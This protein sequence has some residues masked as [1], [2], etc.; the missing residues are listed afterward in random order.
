MLC[1]V[2]LSCMNYGASAQVRS[3]DSGQDF[4]NRPIRVVV[5]Q[6]PGGASDALA[7]IIGQKLA[8]QWRSQLIIDNRGGAGG[9]IGTDIVARSVANGYT[10][11]VTY[12]GTYA[13]N[14][15]LY[16][17]LPFDSRKDFA[18]VATLAAVPFIMVVNNSLPANTLAEFIAIA[19]AKPGDLKYGAANGSVNHLLGVMLDGR[20]G[21]KT[22]HV[23][24]RGAADSLTDTISGQMQ[25]NYA[26][27]PS[28]VQLVRSGRVRAVAVTGG[29]R[30]PALAEVPTIAESGNPGF[31]IAPWFGIFTGA[32]TPQSII[33]KINSDINAL[34]TQ[35]D[36]TDRFANIGAEPLIMTPE[37]FT[38][39]AHRDIEKWGKV[40]K[41]SGATLD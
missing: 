16:R 11:L 17:H 4:P 41:E 28:A 36:V 7:R 38:R 27:L 23:P 30:A 1:G 6:I 21:I 33:R 18:A 24:Y 39:I 14:A 34:L 2:C 29:K 12:E 5:P 32:G 31:D 19:R 20:A 37:Q 25:V 8:E 15:T 35:K 9:N 22:V 3:A 10:W 13:I 26:S 40:V